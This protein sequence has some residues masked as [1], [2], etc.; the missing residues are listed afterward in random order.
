MRIHRIHN[1]EL[2]AQS[3]EK[4]KKYSEPDEKN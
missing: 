4:E 2:K 3:K 1:D